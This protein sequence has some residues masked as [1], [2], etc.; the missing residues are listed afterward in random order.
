VGAAAA[1]IER[2]GLKA[3]LT[4]FRVLATCLLEAPEVSARRR[5]RELRTGG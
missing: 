3:F 1:E 5:T 2:S 4:S